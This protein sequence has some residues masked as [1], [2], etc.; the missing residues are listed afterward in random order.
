MNTKT[1]LYFITILALIGP[2]NF[3]AQSEPKPDTGNINFHTGTVL[4]YSTVSIGYECFD[5]A[6]KSEP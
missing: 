5:L 6:K 1:K 3:R 4:L 2:I